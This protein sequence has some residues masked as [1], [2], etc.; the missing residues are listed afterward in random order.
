MTSVLTMEDLSSI[1]RDLSP[2]LNVAVAERV[3][4]TIPVGIVA[5][6]TGLSLGME[7]S[8]VIGSFD[9]Y[10]EEK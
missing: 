10:E 5:F 6:G 7:R 4:R 1:L 3:L 9:L 8:V 2:G